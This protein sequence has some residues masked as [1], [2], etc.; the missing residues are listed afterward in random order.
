MGYIVGV[1]EPNMSLHDPPEVVLKEV[2]PTE[3]TKAVEEVVVGNNERENLKILENKIQQLRMEKLL[4]IDYVTERIKEME[5][6]FLAYTKE[7]DAVN[8]KLETCDISEITRYREMINCIKGKI[9]LSTQ[10]KAMFNELRLLMKNV[11][12]EEER[13]MVLKARIGDI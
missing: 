11:Q 3:T 9:I 1:S 5:D 13:L 8:K 6:H 12:K 7:L 4:R 2:E 10:R